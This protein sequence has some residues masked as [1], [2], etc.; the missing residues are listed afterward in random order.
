MRNIKIKGLLAAAIAFTTMTNGSQAATEEG[1]KTPERNEYSSTGVFGKFDHASIQRGLQVYIE[2]C[3]AC[4]SLDLVAFRTLED[5][6]YSEDEVK[7]IAIE[8]EYT[9]LDEDGEETFRTG[10]PADYFPA[11]FANDNQAKASNNGALPP[12]FST[13]VKAREHLSFLPWNSVYGEDYIVALMTGYEDEVPA[14]APEG[15]VLSPGTY[16]NHYFSGNAI[17][18]APPL[19]DDMVSYADGT[20]ATVHQMAYDVANFLAWASDPTMQERKELGLRVML[21]MIVFVILLY[22]TNKRVWAKVKKGEDIDPS[23]L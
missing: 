9:E 13:I 17:A 21:F 10:I 20:P 22:F 2:V 11:P 5:V 15:F 7:A 4:H 8:Y 16:Y 19:F 23:K 12:D 18:M 6:G 3:S 14:D 1:L